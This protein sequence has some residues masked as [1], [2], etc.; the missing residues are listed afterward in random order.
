[1]PSGQPFIGSFKIDEANAVILLDPKFTYEYIILEYAASPIQGQEYKI[2]VQFRE[3]LVA[4]LAWLDI[5]SV[6]SSRRGNLGDKR[7]RK[8]EFYNQRRLA[9]AQYKPFHVDEAYKINLESQRLTVKV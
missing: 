3:A 9:F 4:W 6:P 2:P 8:T 1:M 7:D 5:R